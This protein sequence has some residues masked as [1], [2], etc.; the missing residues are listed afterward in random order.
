MD[1]IRRQSLDEWYLHL[2]LGPAAAAGW[3]PRRVCGF[4]IEWHAL[5]EA[6]GEHGVIEVFTGFVH[7]ALRGA[8]ADLLGWS[9][10]RLDDVLQ[11]RQVLRADGTLGPAR[12][13]EP[14]PVVG[15]RVVRAMLS[16]LSVE[17]GWRRA[18]D[19]F[20]LQSIESLVFHQ[21]VGPPPAFRAPRFLHDGSRTMLRPMPVPH[22][23]LHAFLELRTHVDRYRKLVELHAPAPILDAELR[24]QIRPLDAYFA[25]AR[26]TSRQGLEPRTGWVSPLRPTSQPAGLDPAPEDPEIV[27]EPASAVFLDPE[28]LLVQRGTC[29]ERVDL[30]TGRTGATSIPDTPYRLAGADVHQHL[31]FARGG[32]RV[33]DLRADRWLEEV[34]AGMPAVVVNDIDPEEAPIQNVRGGVVLRIEELVEA[35][36]RPTLLALSNDLRFALLGAAHQPTGI[37]CIETGFVHRHLDAPDWLVQPW[38]HTEDAET[39][40]RGWS[41]HP[42]RNVPVALGEQTVPA[43]EWAWSEAHATLPMPRPQRRPALCSSQ[44][45]FRMLLPTG[46]WVDVMEDR[47]IPRALFA[48]DWQAAAFSNDGSQLAL[49]DSGSWAVWDLRTLKITGSGALAPAPFRDD[50]LTL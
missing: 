50:A 18:L 23:L 38:T 37:F 11:G 10:D 17:P 8:I 16:E 27:D 4:W 9:R 19:H 40:Q 31:L 24:E 7:P 39:W 6:M 25:T 44:H 32:V 21:L 14:T 41:T 3:T 33:W 45:G 36:D 29:T 35:A 15:A 46:L 26:Q 22:P 48:R 20:G 42:L 13:G 43:S 34:P 5:A 1:R 49:V 28:Q 2:Q 30:S 12:P 47:V